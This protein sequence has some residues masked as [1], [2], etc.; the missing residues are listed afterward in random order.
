MDI[1]NPIE[2]YEPVVYVPNKLLITVERARSSTIAHIFDSFDNLFK[3]N[4]DRDFLVLVV[5]VLFEMGKGEFSLWGPYFEAVDPGTLACYWPKEVLD[6]IDDQEL[7]WAL[8]E[9]KSS[10]EEQ[11]DLIE[12]LFKIYPE[13]FPQE[14]C[15]YEK[16]KH[17][18]CFVATRCFGWGLPTT[19]V[20]PFADNV[21]HDS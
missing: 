9:Y 14:V 17:A 7:T 6:M 3:A 1:I 11:F 19:I 2:K 18:S 13:H 5:F 15:G 4:E 16:F 21:N 20:V 12:K 8:N 10:M